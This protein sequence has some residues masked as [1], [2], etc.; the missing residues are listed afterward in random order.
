MV[1]EAFEK[2][3]HH[4]AG[5]SSRLAGNLDESRRGLEYHARESCN[6][7]LVHVLEPRPS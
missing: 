2:V 1:Q 4:R 7:N 6:S 5:K 3:K